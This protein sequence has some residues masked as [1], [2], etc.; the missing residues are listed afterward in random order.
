MGTYL[1]LYPVIAAGGRQVKI[2]KR[3]KES[4]ENLN[5]EGQIDHDKLRQPV[6]LRVTQNHGMDQ[7][8]ILRNKTVQ[9]LTVNPHGRG[10]PQ[11]TWDT[12]DGY[13]RPA[14]SPLKPER[15]TQGARRERTRRNIFSKTPY[16]DTVL[17]GS[18]V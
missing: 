3:G 11:I 1:N 13:R 6:V 4:V 12:K 8:Y 15:N 14:P 18:N 16:M 7:I 2:S 9:C 10:Q 17:G 5:Q